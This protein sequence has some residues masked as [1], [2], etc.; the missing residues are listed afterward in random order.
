MNDQ[1]SMNPICSRCNSPL[2]RS[3][4]GEHCPRCAGRL[5]L[6]TREEMESDT[7]N[8]NPSTAPNL[9]EYELGAELGRGAMG[10]VYR[11]RHQRLN[12][13]VAVKLILA[14]RFVGEAARRRFFAEAAL[15][16][17]LDHP[18]IVPIYEVGETAD[19]PFYAMKLVEG[20]TLADRMRKGGESLPTPEF[21]LR[22]FIKIARA[23]HHAHQ[24]GVLH[25]DLKPGNILLDAQGEP[26]I[27][28]FG[29]AR[30]LGVE[31]SLTHSGSSIGT[32]AYMSPE[33]VR[34]DKGI[35]TASDV[36]S[37]GAILYH[38]LTGR[39][40]FE[41]ESAM[42]VMRKVMESDPGRL[43]ND[44]PRLAH[45]SEERRVNRQ[46]KIANQDL[47]TI[48]LKCLE[49]DPAR[50]YA[51][52]LALAE[53]LDRWLNHEP[54]FARP[55]TPVE[56][57]AK[58]VRRRPAVAALAG[59]AALLFVVGTAGIFSQWRRANRHAADAVA[60]LG[61]TR[62]AL[63]QANYDRA[64]ALRV[65]HRPGQRVEA[66]KALRTAAEIRPTPELREEAVAAMA[67][68][69][70]EDVG[71]WM[72]IPT[73]AVETALDADLERIALRQPDGRIEIRRFPGGELLI[74]LTNE[75]PLLR[76]SFADGGDHLLTR[77]LRRYH[78]WNA[79]TGA[80]LFDTLIRHETSSSQL[81]ANLSPDGHWLAHA[82]S[83]SEIAWR[84]LEGTGEAG[85]VGELSRGAEMKFSARAEMLATTSGNQVLVWRLSD[86]RRVGTLTLP[87]SSSGFEWHRTEPLLAIG[88]EDKTAYLWDVLSDK[89]ETLT[90]HRREGVQVY[91]HPNECLL[92]TKSFDQVLRLWDPLARVALL[93]TAR[94]EPRGFSADGRWLA[95]WNPRSLGRLRVHQ[96]EEV[97]LFHP[98]MGMKVRYPR[99][100]PNGEF[101]ASH[102]GSSSLVLWEVASGRRLAEMNLS[103]LKA[104]QFLGGRHL[105]TASREGIALWTN[106]LPGEGWQPAKERVISVGGVEGFALSADARRVLVNQ[107]GGGDAHDLY[108]GRLDL[109]LRGQN[110]FANAAFS[111]DGQWVA[112]GY[113]DNSGQNRSSFWIWSA[114]N[115]QP[116][117]KIPMGNCAAYFSGD[118]RWMLV[119]G[120][121]EYRQY[122]VQG[123]PTN[124]P[125]V[126]R[127]ECEST[128]I[129]DSPAAFSGD[130]TLLAVLTNSTVVRLLEAATG[131]E[132]ARLTPLPEVTGIVSL[133]FD[134]AGRW[135]LADTDLGPFVWNLPLLRARLREM[136]LDWE[137]PPNLALSAARTATPARRAF[138]LA[139]QT[140]SPMPRPYPPR[141]PEATAA[142]IDLEPYFN[143]M[144]TENWLDTLARDN[145]LSSLP[146]GL[147]TLD[148][149]T[150]DIRALI[151]LSG[152][153]LR[154]T[155]PKY[156][157]AVL[158]IKVGVACR[159]LHFL[160]AYGG[161]ERRHGVEAGRYEFLYA[162]GGRETAR[163]RVGE[164]LG[165]FWQ[166]AKNPVTLR[167]ARAAWTGQNDHARSFGCTLQLFHW[168]WENPRPDTVVTSLDFIS[169][170]N[171]PAPF[172]LAIT[173]EE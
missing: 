106:A 87:K 21:F 111:V 126:R 96:P 47:E 60:A 3:V 132:L 125:L 36:W 37:L 58:W 44:D 123:H 13:D 34:G 143:A 35:S 173:V 148:G 139:E 12:R 30:Q 81:R 135:L 85:R 5:L 20:G 95:A 17:Q 1:A 118:G 128:G 63:W 77:D 55:S 103:G 94:A 150:W 105:V 27:T 91:L 19:G 40:P 120:A 48:C 156:P 124:W 6:D 80:L 64:H 147:Q 23:V 145:S 152:A 164:E 82:V 38:L 141:S 39:P 2:A 98:R 57:L 117:R 146:S 59:V 158:E 136:K 24:R 18:H 70:L 56:R 109:H 76:M 113:W 28:D 22:P 61:Q 162:D 65:S 75:L 104:V 153:Q 131:R 45:A 50:R 49:K 46:S 62:D 149:V 154:K 170:M 114:T 79:R 25:R 163:L 92:A 7:I 51:S 97:R 100:S 84:K 151:Q 4:L 160:T 112:S 116:V 15:A 33:Q 101:L 108:S 115:G 107:S 159:R 161:D 9:G 144:L 172:L 43:T 127:F 99:L 110:L 41:G 171:T 68:T 42:E 133:H 138:R 10:V 66:L 169:A 102:N 155:H 137:G 69:D 140:S 11:A 26:H 14:S 166:N 88:C 73:N 121:R 72:T 71:S 142:Q 167:Q 16:A 53:D 8:S 157:A 90:G 129:P 165:D 122:A 32:P 130:G 29:L 134:H 52:A 31:S 78:V 54:I 83:E 86:Q 168:T 93:E 89:V 74:T 67:L 119:A